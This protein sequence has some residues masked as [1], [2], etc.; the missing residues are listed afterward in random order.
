[1]RGTEKLHDRLRFRVRGWAIGLFS[2]WVLAAA[3]AAAAAVAAVA[4][5]AAEP[6]WTLDALIAALKDHNP[7]LEQAR[8][9][10]LAARFQVGVVKSLP[11]PQ[12]NF[13]EQA[14]TGGPFNFEPASGF[15][16]YPTLT[17]PFL[18]PGKR[19]LAGAV[20]SAQ[21][22]V[23]GRGA[24]SLV[25]QLIAQLKITFYQL[26]ALQDQLRY[27]VEDQQRL[28]Q[29]KSIAQVRYANNAAAYVEFLNA[30]VSVSSLA[31]DRFALEK[32]IQAAKDQIN[33]LI[34]RPASSQLVV[35]DSA[36]PP[37]LPARP[38]E[39]LL[40]LAHQ[41]NPAMAGSQSQVDAADQ[42]LALAQQ[43]FRPDFALSAGAY[44]DPLLNHIGSTRM[45]TVGVTVTLPTWGFARE[46]AGV[47]QARAV[48]AQ[49]KAAQE[50]QR[51]QL[52]LNVTMAFHSLE[53]ALRQMQFSRERLLPQAQMAYR[54]ALSGYASNGGTAF[55]DLLMAQGGLRATELALIQAQSA[56]VQA[57][58]TLAA[59]IGRD[60]D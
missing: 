49:A 20:A 16:A 25:I 59:A 22:E 12:L 24:D 19:A 26:V 8:Q 10:Y 42:G 9:A 7:Q 21:A 41:T 57:N 2:T 14:N 32:Q 40:D 38:L 33:L 43:A 51:Q 35:Q 52:D 15:Y 28:E 18:W 17:Q 60:P 34:S 29:I 46:H 58:A 44:T 54:L 50:A 6:P 47:A 5:P 37:H 11:A 39:A 55:A 3:A 48:L 45:Y 30:Q 4:S 13:S 36:G 27:V 31:N 1:M 23:V 56:A 53:T